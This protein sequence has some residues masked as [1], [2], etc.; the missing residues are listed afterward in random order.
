M[1]MYDII[2]K[3]LNRQ[4]L[5]KEEIE[6]FVSEYSSD[7]IPDYQASALLAAI[8][9][10]G[11]TI[12]EITNLTL[13][14]A[15]SSD[16][17]D[18][19]YIKS[20]NKRFVV[21]K[22]STGGVG[23]KVTLIVLPII[24]SLGVPVAKMSGRGLGFTGGTADKIESIEGINIELSF[25]EFINQV[26]EISMALITQNENI[27]I[28]D[29]KMYALRD[30]TATVSSLP[31]I[32]SSIMSKKI[33]SGADKI[34]LDVTYG[35]GAFMKTYEKA[36]KLA[37]IMVQIGKV[38]GKETRA[39]ITSMEE[40]LGKK[41]G[42]AVEIDEVIEFLT[43]DEESLE[44]I[45]ASDLKEVVFE[46]GAHMIDLAGFGSNIAENKQKMKE[47]ILDGRAYNKFIEFVKAQGGEI[48]EQVP[49]LKRKVK[50]MSYLRATKEGYISKI[51]GE[52]IGKTLVEM[53]GGRKEKGDY[54]DYGVGMSF[55]KKIGEYVKIDD[56]I[57]TV[58]YNDI[59][60]FSEILKSLENAVE[61]SDVKPKEKVC[62]REIIK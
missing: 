17:L 62:I 43:S 41:V 60:K 25:E 7:R 29:K 1:R 30:V 44:D 8:Y 35:S 18:L 26:N 56:E 57:I 42:N 6:Y 39:V 58:Y 36:K 53:G 2:E 12:D 45:V 32:A 9:V 15:M 22:H 38:V 28:A 50:Y 49:V 13:A 47:A 31:L 19:S 4:K 52:L 27:D 59:D 20:A 14:M 21:D 61:I 11:M 48:E 10:N 16:T 5:S 54:I 40:P 51:D 46:I 23:D 3:K 24:A 37:M 34:L 55:E 33:A